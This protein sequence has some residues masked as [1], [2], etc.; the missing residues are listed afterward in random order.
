MLKAYQGRPSDSDCGRQKTGRSGR[1]PGV[2][3]NNMAAFLQQQGYWKEV[4]EMPVNVMAG[5]F[6]SGYYYDGD[7]TYDIADDYCVSWPVYPS[8]KIQWKF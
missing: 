8:F 7:Y 4:M 5:G 6:E 2:I 1:K 3:D